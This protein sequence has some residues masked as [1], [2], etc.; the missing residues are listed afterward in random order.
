M[1]IRKSGWSWDNGRVLLAC[2][3]ISSLFMAICSKSSFLYPINDWGDANAYVTAAKMMINGRVLY[4]EIFEQKGL[5]L[6][7]VHILTSLVS[8][9]SF[10]GVYLMEVL[11]FAGFLFFAYKTGTLFV[12]GR[13]ML[14]VLPVLAYTVLTSTAFCHGDSAEELLLPLLAYSLFSMLRWSKYSHSSTR[15]NSRTWIMQGIV[16]AVIFWT[17][18]TILG[19][20]I[21]FCVAIAVIHLK[22][23]DIKGLFNVIGWWMGGVVIGSI[24]AIAYF[25]ITNTFMDMFEVYIKSNIFNYGGFST[26]QF[27]LVVFLKRIL[28]SIKWNFLMMLSAFF[29]F[30][31]IALTSKI[32]ENWKTKTVVWCVYIG[33]FTFSLG[34]PRFYAYYSLVI[35][36]LSILGFIILISTIDKL[37]SIHIK[38]WHAMLIV[39]A[40]LLFLLPT[41][42]FTSGNTYLMTYSKEELPQFQFKRIISQDKETSLLTHMNLDNGF[43]N[44]CGIVPDYKYFIATNTA[45]PERIDAWTK[46]IENGQVDYLLSRDTRL[47]DNYLHFPYELL[48]SSSYFFEGAVRDYRLYRLVK[49]I[50]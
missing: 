27:S 12:P 17:K 32:G 35:A 29:G 6:Y 48:A 41:S 47:E 50:P 43:Q 22:E 38:K 45:V 33:V 34:M 25:G 44:L 49:K 26:N 46:M 20:H 5:Y 7:L 39:V 9:P 19:F 23:Q 31:G 14:L 2:G 18:Y 8:Y 16:T 21:G 3:V 36:V 1:H 15:S 11:T 4:S 10:F 42:Y 28:S 40:L 24:P 30:L 37:R 13:L